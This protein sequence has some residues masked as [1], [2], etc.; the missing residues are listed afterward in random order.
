MPTVGDDYIREKQQGGLKTGIVTLRDFDRGVVETLGGVVIDDNYYVTVPGVAPSPEQPGIP[1][2]FAFPED[3][4]EHH[5]KP[6]FIVSREDI[7][8]A[9]QRWHPGALQYRAPADTARPVV[10]NGVQGFSSTEQMA[11][12]IP[13]DLS[14]TISII[15]A[16]NRNMAAK[17]LDWTLRRYPP[18]CAVYVLD[19]LG[20]QRTYTAWNDGVGM[21]DEIAEVSERTIGFAVTL[22]VEAEFDLAEPEIHS[23]VTRPPVMNL[24]RK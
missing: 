2:T 22:R 13:F 9:M 11:Q 24:K 8:P 19:S 5:R 17:L 6:G 14:Y 1:I 23:T 3:I 20:D 21:L 7:A 4:Y 16:G 18:Y 12:A 10:L 15:T